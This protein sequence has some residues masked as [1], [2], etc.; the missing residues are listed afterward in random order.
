MTSIA[1]AWGGQPYTE[2]I[3]NDVKP[4]AADHVANTMSESEMRQYVRAYLDRTYSLFG[5]QGIVKLLRPDAVTDIRNY[6]LSEPRYWSE[7]DIVVVLVA[8]AVLLIF[9]E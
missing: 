9:V 6:A 7:V 4:Q 3:V 8:I 2:P 1:E 5:P